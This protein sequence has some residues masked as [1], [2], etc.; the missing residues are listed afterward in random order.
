MWFRPLD[1]TNPDTSGSDRLTISVSWMHHYLHCCRSLSLKLLHKSSPSSCTFACACMHFLWL[2]KPNSPSPTFTETNS[3]TTNHG[4]LAALPESQR[5]SALQ[6]FP[7]FFIQ[8]QPNDSAAVSAGS[9]GF[10]MCQG[11]SSSMR[12]GTWSADRPTDVSVE[13]SR[14]NNLKELKSVSACH[15][16]V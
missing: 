14:K 10:D 6:L 11:A 4:I 3:P 12:P 7:T 8:A 2:W 9:W 1:P 5:R 16:G 15:A 13:R